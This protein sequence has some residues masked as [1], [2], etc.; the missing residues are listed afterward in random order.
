M[1]PT[2]SISPPFT[3]FSEQNGSQNAWCLYSQEKYGGFAVTVPAFSQA[4]VVAT[5]ASGRPC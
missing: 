4:K 2:P 5:F 3:A 1:A